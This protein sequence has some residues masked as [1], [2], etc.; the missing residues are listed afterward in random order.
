MSKIKISNIKISNIKLTE[1]NVLENKELE[2][3]A[4]LMEEDAVENPLDLLP[5][6]TWHVVE[7]KLSNTYAGF[8]NGLRRILIEEM[9]VKCISFDEKEMET[10]DEFIL[11][12]ILIK[13]IN[14][15]PIDQAI[16]D[17]DY[18]ITLYVE[19]F[20]P[21]TI[22]IKAKD[23]SITLGKKGKQI[24]ITN[25]IPDPNILIVRLRAGKKLF[26]KKLFVEQGF[27]KNDA[28]KFSLLDN[29][30][31]DILDMEPHNQFTHKGTRSIEYD[32][33]E[34]HLSF[35]TSGN[36]KPDHVINLMCD[37][38]L[39]K[40]ERMK[41][42]LNEYHKSI[43]LDNESKYYFNEELEVTYL[44][45]VITFRFFKEYITLAY[46]IAHRCYML[47]STISFCTPTID[48]YDNEIAIIKLKHPSP[49]KLLIAACD[50]CIS[51]INLVRH[52]LLM[53]I[54]K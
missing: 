7:F 40:I 4:K 29:T 9:P 47:D 24:P 44:D 1:H 12:D 26:I 36:I 8:A 37:V 50:A 19:N 52:D 5:K 25:L 20:T 23:I 51:D 10:D 2:Y 6:S 49:T 15:L 14:L 31:Y 3:Y 41:K 33:K 38:A 21:K 18:H 22:D 32:P 27:A 13:N 45:E 43:S 39:E 17:S 48:R 42:N 16:N 46:M 11:N 30:T 34:F 28:A 54:K 35:T 53:G